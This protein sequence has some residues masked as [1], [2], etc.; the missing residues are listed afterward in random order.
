[1]RQP[2]HSNGAHRCNSQTGL[3][4]PWRGVHSRFGSLT[5]DPCER[6]V[7][8]C[9]L[10]TQSR[11]SL[12]EMKRGRFSQ[13]PLSSDDWSTQEL[14]AAPILVPQQLE[15]NVWIGIGTEISSIPAV[16]LRRS[17]A[18]GSVRAGIR[19]IMM[20]CLAFV[21]RSGK[22]RCSYQGCCANDG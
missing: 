4:A 1:M 3:A 5:T 22:R 15:T 9:L 14:V 17:L 10:L 16:Y 2:P 21:N 11:H 13:P 18:L 19:C 12:L 8:P 6:A 7:R 20:Q